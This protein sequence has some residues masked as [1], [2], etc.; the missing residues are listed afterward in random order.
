MSFF[1]TIDVNAH[2]A[3]TIARGLYAIAAVDG[4]HERELALISEFAWG[5]TAD[6]DTGGGPLG[7]GSF[8]RITP[9]EPASVA[10]LL[11]G[12]EIRELFMK[13]GLLVAY[14]DGNVSAAERKLLGQFAEAL[15]LAAPALARLEA[16]VKDYM[17]R[18]LSKLN[19]VEAVAKVAKKLGA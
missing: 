6:D 5:A 18:S 11:P 8:G 10:L 13:A 2:E 17:L 1:P 15:G 9:L 14:A 7:G 12:A 3:E 16:E 19:N 4:V